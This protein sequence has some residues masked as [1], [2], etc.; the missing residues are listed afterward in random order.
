MY[1]FKYK[2]N[3]KNAGK[4]RKDACPLRIP[5]HPNVCLPLPPGRL[6]S[7]VIGDFCHYVKNT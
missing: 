7:R 5:D 2:I 6:P 1:G 4:L 3:N